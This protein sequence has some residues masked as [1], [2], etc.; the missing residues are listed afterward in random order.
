[1]NPN[2]NQYD[3]ITNSTASQKKTPTSQKNRVIQVVGGALLLLVVFTVIFS[4]ISS[5]GGGPKDEFLQLGAAQEDLIGVTKVGRDE[6]RSSST[7]SE[8]QMLL[9]TATSQKNATIALMQ[10]YGLPKNPEKQFAKYQ[11]KSYE[12]KLK[13]ATQS[14][15]FESTYKTILADKLGTYRAKLQNLYAKLEKTDEKKQFS[16]YYLELETLEPTAKQ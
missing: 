6:S 7:Q 11:D 2:K 5:S 4:F 12:E 16:D 3:F 10:E 1:M 15:S 13:S 8:A 14:N 9:M